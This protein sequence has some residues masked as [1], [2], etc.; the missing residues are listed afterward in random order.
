MSNLLAFSLS[1]P[2]FG[3]VGAVCVVIHLTRLIRS[4]DAGGGA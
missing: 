3:F 1:E 2:R 4:N